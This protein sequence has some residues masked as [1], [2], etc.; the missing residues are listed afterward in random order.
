MRLST[1]IINNNCK[2]YFR[3]A[4]RYQ[5]KID[6]FASEENN[7]N[8]PDIDD[9]SEKEWKEHIIKLA[10]SSIREGFSEQE[11]LCLNLILKATPVETISESLN[12]K[13]NTAYVMRQRII[14]KLN[15]KVRFLNEELG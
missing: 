15:R 2:N 10:S 6:K 4:S 11:S 3:T 9:I 1:S 12:L 5:N 14:E 7:N 13:K 8:T